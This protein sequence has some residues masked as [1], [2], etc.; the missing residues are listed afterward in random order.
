MSAR[1]AT[2]RPLNDAD[3]HDD[4]GRAIAYVHPSGEIVT[5]GPGNAATISQL[6]ARHGVR[7]SG[8]VVGPDPVLPKLA[9]AVHYAVTGGTADDRWHV[10][11]ALVRALPNARRSANL[12][13]VD[14]YSLREA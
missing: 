14:V 13:T 9:R 7:I 2:Y 4:A 12:H 1:G 11:D 10:A 8:A 5:P 6:A 3:A